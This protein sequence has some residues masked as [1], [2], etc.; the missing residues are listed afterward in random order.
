MPLM[1]F[2]HHGRLQDRPRLGGTIGPRRKPLL[3]PAA[4]EEEV[5]RTAA[6]TLIVGKLAEM[7]P[8]SALVR[9]AA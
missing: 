3:M 2:C 8:S 5:G 6:L 1:T 4:A 7:S 9:C